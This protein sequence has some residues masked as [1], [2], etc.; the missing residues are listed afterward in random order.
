[1]PVR[2]AENEER[3]AEDAHRIAALRRRAVA[4][5]EDV[6]VHADEAADEAPRTGPGGGRSPEGTDGPAPG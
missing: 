3:A 4:E 1:M 6:L 2:V 5:A